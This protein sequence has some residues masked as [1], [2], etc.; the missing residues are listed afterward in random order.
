M[1]GRVFCLGTAT[2][3][4]PIGSNTWSQQVQHRPLG[5]DDGPISRLHDGQRWV[6]G[7]GDGR[8]RRRGCL[9][10]GRRLGLVGAF[11]VLKSARLSKSARPPGPIT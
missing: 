7:H 3:A 6:G 2:S 11:I 10:L 4:P 9:G 1:P 8:R 5:S